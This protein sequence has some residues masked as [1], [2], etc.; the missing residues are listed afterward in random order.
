MYNVM[1]NIQINQNDWSIILVKILADL[2][3]DWTAVCL[4]EEQKYHHPI[5]GKCF[6]NVP[7]QSLFPLVSPF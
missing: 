1:Q 4:M 5:H 6:D 2:L 7:L 3:G